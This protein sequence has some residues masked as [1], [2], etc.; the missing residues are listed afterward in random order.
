MYELILVCSFCLFRLLHTFH[1][2]DMHVLY[3]FHIPYIRSELHRPHMQISPM[4]IYNSF[5]NVWYC[6]NI[7][8]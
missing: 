4:N 7:E 1:N 3:G 8:L 5:G 2:L 6:D